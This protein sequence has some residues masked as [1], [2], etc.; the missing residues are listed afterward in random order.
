MERSSDDVVFLLGLS[1]FPFEVGA[2]QRGTSR[3]VDNVA[4]GLKGVMA[5]VF[6]RL[7]LDGVDGSTIQIPLYA[8]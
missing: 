1:W 6:L 8:Q 5:K 2:L 7:I 3:I 4:D